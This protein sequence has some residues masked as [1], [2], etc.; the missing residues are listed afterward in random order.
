MKVL[1]V[2][3]GTGNL[4]IPAAKTGADVTGIDI[5]PNLIDGAIARAKEEDVE[6]KFEVGDAEAL[7]TRT[8][9]SIS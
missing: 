9:A 2:A 8:T 3:C 5:A 6:A 4:A 7:P 1:D